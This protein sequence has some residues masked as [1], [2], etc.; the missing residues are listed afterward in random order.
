MPRLVQFPLLALLLVGVARLGNA[1][2]DIPR[3][4]LHI[5]GYTYH[6][7]A[8]NCNDLLLGSGITW[9][10]R[11]DDRLQAAWEADAFADSARKLSAYAGY[12]V[13]LP[14]H[15]VAVGATAAIMYHRNFVAENRYRTLPVAFPFLEAGTRKFKVR[16]YYVPPVRRASDEQFA[17]QLLLPIWK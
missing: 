11:Y 10:T 8:Q 13:A 5:D 9:Y 4:W 15:G 6:V 1:T 17:V 16:L 12:S 3:G 14:F 2:E 7:V